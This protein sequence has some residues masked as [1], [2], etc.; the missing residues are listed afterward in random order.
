MQA[1]TQKLD[2]CALMS[3]EEYNRWSLGAHQLATEFAN[4]KT[5]RLEYLKLFT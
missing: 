4:S 1:Y 2:H 5:R 3:P